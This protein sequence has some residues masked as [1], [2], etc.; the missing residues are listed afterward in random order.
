MSTT[1]VSTTEESPFGKVTARFRNPV[2]I[3]ALLTILGLPSGGCRRPLGRMT[4]KGID[5]VRETARQV[6]TANPSILKPAA[7]FFNIDIDQR[8]NDDALLDDL[9]Y[10]EY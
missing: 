9:I 1:T 3:K 2:G 10:A 4:R 5:F 7:E 6:Q 8:L